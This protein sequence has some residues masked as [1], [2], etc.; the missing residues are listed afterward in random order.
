MFEYGYEN[1][2][3]IIE[4]ENPN[5]EETHDLVKDK[6]CNILFS[7]KSRWILKENLINRFDGRV[8]NIHQGNLPFER[9]G[10]APSQRILKRL[11]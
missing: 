2:L 1:S 10:T 11:E 5:Q 9:G 7:I 8:V 6:G 3:E 4:I